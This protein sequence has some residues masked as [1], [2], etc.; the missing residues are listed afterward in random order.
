MLHF[1][2]N[3][4]TKLSLTQHGQHRGPACWARM[5]TFS[6][7]KRGS[8]LGR[9]EQ[10]AIGRLAS[11]ALSSLACSGHGLAS[12]QGWS[13]AE[14]GDGT[15]W[16]GSGVAGAPKAER[17]DT[18]SH[19]AAVEPP[20][21][22]AATGTME[23]KRGSG[24]DDAAGQ[25]CR[26]RSHAAQRDRI[27]RTEVGQSCWES[28]NEGQSEPE[29]DHETRR[30]RLLRQ[31]AAPGL[32]LEAAGCRRRD[33]LLELPALHSTLVCAARRCESAASTLRPGCTALVSGREVCIT[34]V[35]AAVEQAST[36]Q[37]Q[38]AR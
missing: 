28:R 30:P 27:Q 2:D 4:T 34:L 26:S 22:W 38:R 15:N 19:M 25:S 33:E 16:A 21:A 11:L 29:P 8:A 20:A 12:C 9:E 1:A 32:S 3:G 23:G 37:A 6:C 35:K 17:Q 24:R 13:C 14:V 10:A 31:H 5:L 36:A 7:C 18:A